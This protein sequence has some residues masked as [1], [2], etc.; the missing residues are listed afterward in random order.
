MLFFTRTLIIV[1]LY[2]G[3]FG[4]AAFGQSFIFHPTK[5]PTG[6]W[7]PQGLAFEDAWFDAAD[8]HALHGWYIPA[9]EPVGFLLYA[10]GNGGNLS[11]RAPVL[12]ELNQLGFSVFIFDYRGYGRSEGEP[13]VDGILEDGKAALAWLM[14]RESI[15]AHSVTFIGRSLGSLVAI[16]LA[17]TSDARALILD[18]SFPSL[19]AAAKEM[20]PWLP[21]DLLI[22]RDIDATR[23]IQAYHGP[24]LQFHGTNDT[25][26]PL[27][28][29]QQLYAAANEPKAFVELDGLGH[30]DIRP[31]DYYDAILQVHR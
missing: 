21:V 16:H 23:L 26:I 27:R 22:R 13:T 24:L 31:Q 28:L 6:N 14:E 15:A 19:K 10:H 11:D 30:N 2:G 12:K 9:T 25:L 7:Q 17:A 8:G 1:F 3:T 18:S 20:Y 4:S 29:G 5:Y